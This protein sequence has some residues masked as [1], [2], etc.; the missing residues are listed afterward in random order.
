MELFVI[1]SL[2]LLGSV[3]FLKH[4]LKLREIMVINSSRYRFLVKVASV[5]LL[6]SSMFAFLML[7]SLFV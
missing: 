3:A 5:N 7:M 2:Y 1:L 6:F 4:S